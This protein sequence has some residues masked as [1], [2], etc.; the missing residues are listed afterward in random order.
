VVSLFVDSVAS[1]TMELSKGSTVE[2]ISK[3]RKKRQGNMNSHNRSMSESTGSGKAY[4]RL[5][6]QS[7][8]KFDQKH[9]KNK[10]TKIDHYNSMYFSNERAGPGSYNL[11]ALL[12]S[13]TMETNK[14]NYPAFSIGTSS[15]DKLLVL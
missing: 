11:P 10:N 9:A 4:M 12:G 1:S 13:F 14:K 3:R 7:K 8:S 6:S 15:K 5:Y 2:S